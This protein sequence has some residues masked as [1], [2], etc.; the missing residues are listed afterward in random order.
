MNCEHMLKVVVFAYASIGVA[1]SAIFAGTRLRR[2]GWRLN[3]FELAWLF[4]Y[5]SRA[6]R[7]Y[8]LFQLLGWPVIALCVALVICAK[9][10]LS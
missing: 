4:P 6:R 3:E 9:S 1:L 8:R 10:G 7:I 5:S 2:S